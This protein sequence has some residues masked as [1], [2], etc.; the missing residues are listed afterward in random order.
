MIGA[1][2]D[3][4]AMY[5][6][7]GR[8]S[9]QPAIET[10]SRYVYLLLWD[11][12]WTL[13]GAILRWMLS[14]LVFCNSMPVVEAKSSVKICSSYLRFSLWQARFTAQKK[15]F[16]LFA[17][18]L[19]CYNI[20]GGGRRIKNPPH[21][22]SCESNDTM[23]HGLEQNLDKTCPLVHLQMMIGHKLQIQVVSRVKFQR[24]ILMGKE[25]MTPR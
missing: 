23:I 21:L 7:R 6:I 14:M 18:Y 20:L 12:C 22:D 13:V 17:I 10:D 4:P 3:Q 16:R 8:I 19:S 9:F 24:L 25:D 15:Y 11:G 1:G 2:H 5:Y